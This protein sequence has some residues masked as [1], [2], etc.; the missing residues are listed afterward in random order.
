MAVV[1]LGIATAAS[2]AVGLGLA[3]VVAA[4]GWGAVVYRNAAEAAARL[5]QW[6][7]SQVCLACARKF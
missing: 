6:H 2:G 7:G 4:V 3:V 1:V 5:E